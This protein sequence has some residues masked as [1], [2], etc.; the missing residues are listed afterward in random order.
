MTE[1]M[2]SRLLRE[3]LNAGFIT[4]DDGALT[5]LD[6]DGYS[7][8]DS[9]VGSTLVYSLNNY[10]DL[11]GYSMKDLT[12]YIQGA[13]FQRIGPY[14]YSQM[15]DDV[16]ITEIIVLSTTPLDINTDFNQ[17][18]IPDAVP[19]SMTSTTELQAI[20][21][22][23]VGVYSQDAGAGFGRLIESQTWGA[24][25][26]TAADRLY[27]HRL[28]IFP[29]VKAAGGNAS[30]G[31]NWPDLGMVVPIIV[32]KESDLEYMMRLARSLEPVY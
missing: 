23:W 26:A 13:M 21:Q 14:S 11:T 19:G 29:K 5:G 16:F 30:Y 27:Y 15:Q 3:Q 10:F 12:T 18:P 25:D 32:D 20:I 22:G 28:F 1:E 8:D 9:A 6:A 7:V 2:K 17:F 31:F 4:I 24:G